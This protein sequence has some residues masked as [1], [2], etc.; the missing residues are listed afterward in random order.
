[1]TISNESIK[2][3]IRHHISPK[4]QEKQLITKRYNDL[5]SII[6]G[7]NFQS[8][9]YA[10]FTAITPVNDLDVIWELPEDVLK[11]E[12]FTELIVKKTI[13]P[14]DL[15]VSNILSELAGR[16]RLEY[17]KQGF[18]V[19]KI[20]PQSH[21]VGVYFGPTEDDFSIDIVPAIPKGKNE[22]GDSTYI[23]PEILRI[24]KK[25]RRKKY[26]SLDAIKWVKSGLT[27]SPMEATQGQGHA[28]RQR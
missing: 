15:D 21:S 1:M 7:H 26:K 20:E 4:D 25:L 18:S 19:L 12:K 8:G 24:D 11:Q 22:Y 28:L 5:S 6:K 3:H 23:V 13:D 10:R 17:E 16:L 27:V 2:N 9:S 14:T